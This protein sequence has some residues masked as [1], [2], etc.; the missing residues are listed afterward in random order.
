[1]NNVQYGTFDS[2]KYYDVGDIQDLQ[3]F[4]RRLGTLLNTV[5]F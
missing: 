3:T 4:S 5:K 2:T 1:M